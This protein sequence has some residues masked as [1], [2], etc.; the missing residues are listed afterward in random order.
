MHCKRLVFCI[1]LLAFSTSSCFRIPK[2]GTQQTTQR[3]PTNDAAFLVSVPITK[4]SSIQSPCID[5]HIDN[6]T[7]S[8]ELDL[9][10]RGDLTLANKFI[11]QISSKTFILT[12]PMYGVRGKEYSTDL[13]RIPKI[14]IGTLA[15]IKPVLQ[16][17]GE[18]FTED[19]VFV[20]EGRKP[21]PREDG[22]VG[23]ELFYNVNLLIDIK[24]SKIIFCDSLDTLKKHGYLIKNF[25]KVPLFLERGLLEFEAQINEG[26]LRCMLDTGSTWNILNTEIE[27]GKSIEQVMWEPENTLTYPSFKIGKKDFGSIALHR[28]PIKLPIHIE[29]ILGMEFF[30]D[31]LV[32][33]DFTGG[34]VYFSDVHW[35]TTKG[36]KPATNPKTPQ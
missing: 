14:K 18:E 12:K 32:F 26:A 1:C 36:L 3:L 2:Q 11:D 20:Q 13:Y 33:L 25:T 34:S 17:K 10:F 29:A 19:A 8:M 27:D 23:W 15:F 9:G 16:K 24:N 22:R 31:H 21:S 7:F 4:F 28:I 6:T 30:Q 35:M 5:V